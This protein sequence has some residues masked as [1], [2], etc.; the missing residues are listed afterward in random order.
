ME[1]KIMGASNHRMRNFLTELR[2]RWDGKRVMIVGHRAT[3]YAL[4]NL[5]NGKPLEQ[6]VT[7]PWSWQAGWRY[8][9]N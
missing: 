8:Q 6:C 4:E 7:E 2:A 5:L 3:Q 1:S 9:L